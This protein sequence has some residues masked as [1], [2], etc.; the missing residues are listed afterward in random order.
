M[1]TGDS[2]QAACQSLNMIIKLL[3]TRLRLDG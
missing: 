2:G 1:H 3:E